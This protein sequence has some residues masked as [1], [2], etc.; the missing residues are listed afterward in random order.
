MAC[1]LNFLF[2]VFWMVFTFLL[3]WWIRVEL[4]RGEWNHFG[5]WV[6]AFALDLELHYY[7]DF[8]TIQHL[9]H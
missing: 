6:R 1:L 9:H 8:C 3:E 7:D 5:W 4:F 2:F